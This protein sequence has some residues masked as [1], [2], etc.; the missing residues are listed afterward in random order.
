[1][2]PRKIRGIVFIVIGL[3]LINSTKPLMA[4]FLNVVH[5]LVDVAIFVLSPIGLI[6]LIIGIY[7][8]ATK[9][10]EAVKT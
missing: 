5:P 7:R 3:V 2:T 1:M 9:G 4:Q 10:K 8:I 6:F